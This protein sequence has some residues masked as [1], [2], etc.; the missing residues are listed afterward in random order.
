MARGESKRKPRTAVDSTT[1]PLFASAMSK[2]APSLQP[3]RVETR[4]EYL[5]CGLRTLDA[6]LRGGLPVGDATLVAARP[7]V[8]STSFLLGA[9][10]AALKRGERVAYFS[11]GLREEQ[12][13]GRFVV[14]ESRVNGY[15]FRAGFVTAEDRV[16]LAAARARIPWSA[17]S[18]VARRKIVPEDID[19]HLFSYRPWLVIADVL[20]RGSSGSTSRKSSDLMAGV[21]KLVESARKHQ[22]AL[23]V[24]AILPQAEHPPNRLELPGVG[25]MAE[26][27]SSVVLLHREEVTDPAGVPDQATGMAEAFVVRTHGHDVEPRVVSLRFD[28]RFAGLL[29]L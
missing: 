27:F 8:G 23:L 12:V 10:L 7:K 16:A 15:R 2:P 29:D 28:Q 24:R 14:L 20:P 13:R 1:L 19:G 26:A 11:E 5:S 18:I 22:V 25:A 3:S 4:P 17:L 21:E 9:A 6:A